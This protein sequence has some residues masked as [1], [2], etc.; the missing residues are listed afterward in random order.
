MEVPD[1]EKEPASPA[2]GP[3]PEASGNKVGQAA[4]QGQD[5]PA[6]SRWWKTMAGPSR[7]L[8]LQDLRKALRRKRDWTQSRRTV[9]ALRLCMH[10]PRPAGFPGLLLGAG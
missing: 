1:W 2:P 9:L 6:A 8:A 4:V 7:V 3:V 10:C 5:G